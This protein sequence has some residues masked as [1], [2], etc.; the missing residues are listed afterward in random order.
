MKKTIYT[1]LQVPAGDGKRAA[2]CQ[3]QQLPSQ[4]V[5]APFDGSLAGSVLTKAQSGAV[6]TL[7]N[8]NESIHS[9]KTS[10]AGF[11]NGSLYYTFCGKKVLLSDLY[12]DQSEAEFAPQEPASFETFDGTEATITRVYVSV[13]GME[14]AVAYDFVS[15]KALPLVQVFVSL[16]PNNAE[17]IFPFQIGCLT[18]EKGSVTNMLAGLPKVE[19]PR[20]DDLYIAENYISFTADGVNFAFAGGYPALQSADGIVKVKSDCQSSVKTYDISEYG[21]QNPF[22]SNIVCSREVVDAESWLQNIPCLYAENDLLGKNQIISVGDLKVVLGDNGQGLELLSIYDIRK[23]QPLLSRG[24]N[25]LFT[26]NLRHVEDKSKL[27]LNSREGWGSIQTTSTK[28]MHTWVFSD[29]KEAENISVILTAFCAP[30]KSR[31]S[32]DLT[33]QNESAVY[34]VQDAEYPRLT[35]NTDNNT[36]LLSPYGSGEIRRSLS[37][38]AAHASLNYP[39]FGASFQFGAVYNTDLGCGIYYGVHDPAPAYKVCNFD[40]QLFKQ[41]ISFGFTYPFSLIDK[42]GNSSSLAGKVVWQLF[43]GDWYDA[44]MIYKEFVDAEANWLP[45]VD[46]NGPVNTPDWMKTCSHWWRTCLEDPRM[47]DD[48]SNWLNETLEAQKDLGIPCADHVY[49]WH[50]TVFDNEYPHF[51]P[52]RRE[53]IRGVP[54]M[55]EAGIKLVPYINSRC[56]DTLDGGA[57]DWEYTSKALSETTKDLDG[58]TFIELSPFNKPNGGPKVQLAVMCPS[59]VMWQDLQCE[60]VDK[61]YNELGMDGV[62]L[63]QIAA[64]KPNLCA[65]PHHNHAAGGGSWWMDNYHHMVSRMKTHGPKTGALVTECTGEP[66]MKTIEALLSWAWVRNS[67]VPAFSSIYGG[68]VAMV[69][70]DYDSLRDEE[71]VKIFAAQSFLFGEQMGWIPPSRYLKTCYRAFYKKCV[72]TRDAHK[73]FFYAGKLLR[74]LAIESDQSPITTYR[75]IMAEGQIV[76]APAVMGAHWKKFAGD[77]ELIVLINLSNNA[78]KTEV[79][80]PEGISSLKLEGD[81]NKDVSCANGKLSV[82]LPAQSVVT[83]IIE[84]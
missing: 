72:L 81:I 25:M 65:D 41:T 33:V 8:G 44:C 83:S 54:L 71:G 3:G 43:D 60:L 29:H 47:E 23:E 20:E 52:A 45:E 12:R 84:R 55:H 6:L 46:E 49:H 13:K 30:E 63:D 9:E 62:Y 59:S 14:K 18:F 37:S 53:F 31:I 78:A 76:S 17:V 35:M 36:T 70:R 40:K 69:G 28:N 50:Q 68:R 11:E 26:L 7:C 51:F 57:D 61:L 2:C 82:T 19:I 74:P 48:C 75:C 39:G 34:S 64:A 16:N 24:A 42:A 79:T 77:Q 1:W 22:V 32:W 27:H 21:P 73:E 66:Y 80:L 4:F 58:N 15:Y 10:V 5:P 56:W 67:Q 38:A